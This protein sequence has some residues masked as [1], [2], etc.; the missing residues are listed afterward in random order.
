VGIE[1]I[2]EFPFMLSPSTNQP[3]ILSFVE[4]YGWFAQDRHV[5]A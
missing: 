2:H 5:E 1:I 4:G 3:F